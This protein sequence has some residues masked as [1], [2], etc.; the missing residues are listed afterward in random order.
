MER[1]LLLMEGSQRLL[2]KRG[3]RANRDNYPFE[4]LFEKIERARLVLAHTGGIKGQNA[5]KIKS[6][7]RRQFVVSLITALEVYLGDIVLE[8]IDTQ[9]V[10]YSENILKSAGKKFNIIEIDEIL[11][12]KITVGELIC[13]QINFQNLD[14]T[15]S[16]LTDLFDED[17]AKLLETK[18]FVYTNKQERKITLSLRKGFKKRL[19]R[20]FELRHNYVHDISFNN[21]P[22]LTDL[23]AYREAIFRLAVCIDVKVD[24]LRGDDQS[25]IIPK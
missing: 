12:N 4:N 23:T 11:K 25:A 6:E 16:F 13:D 24:S 1:R 5:N 22:S 3:L 2:E 19:A 21:T 14:W 9:K 18:K 17:F 8:L 15:L 20:I 10:K 7:A